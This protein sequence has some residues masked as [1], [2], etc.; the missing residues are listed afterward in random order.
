M[1]IHICIIYIEKYALH[2]LTYLYTHTCIT[3]IYICTHGY[4]LA[5]LLCGTVLDAEPLRDAVKLVK[6]ELGLGGPLAV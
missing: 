3:P 2:I 6:W 5:V 4:T 1:Y